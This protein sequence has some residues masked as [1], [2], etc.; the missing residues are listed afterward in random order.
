MKAP[1]YST[2]QVRAILQRVR[3]NPG[4]VEPS[5]PPWCQCEGRNTY[6][7]VHGIQICVMG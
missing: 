7:N 2:A 5:T 1:Y 4:W 3:E 6:Y